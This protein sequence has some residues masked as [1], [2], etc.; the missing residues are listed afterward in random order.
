MIIANLKN[1]S[2][3]TLLDANEIRVAKGLKVWRLEHADSLGVK[4]KQV[5][6]D[7]SID[8][9]VRNKRNNPSW[10]SRKET[11]E[12]DLRHCWG[13]GKG[14][15]K[16]GGTAF[17]MNNHFEENELYKTLIEKSREEH[18][19]KEMARR[20]EA[21]KRIFNSKNKHSTTA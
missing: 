3:I 19:A 13:F 21:A 5:L 16:P 1:L 4:A 8:E 18:T 7:R 12:F 2:K 15:A 17:L 14:K 11:S 6:P 20:K 10:A 9:F